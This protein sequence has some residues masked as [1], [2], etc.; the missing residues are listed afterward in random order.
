MR[1]FGILS[2]VMF[3]ATVAS[4]GQSLPAAPAGPTDE[5]IVHQRVGTSLDSAELAYFGLFQGQSPRVDSARFGPITGGY[6]VEPFAQ[7]HSQKIVF[8]PAAQN[9]FLRFIAWYERLALNP[10]SNLNL[11]LLRPLGVQEPLIR[12]ER[13]GRFAEVTLPGGTYFGELLFVSNKAIALY[14]VDLGYEASLVETSVKIFPVADVT[15]LKVY[16]RSFATITGLATGAAVGVAMTVQGYSPF[17][18]KNESAQYAANLLVFPALGAG[19]GF[20]IDKAYGIGFSYDMKNP[21]RAKKGL[22]RA[23]KKVM[24]PRELP[25]EL[26]R[27]LASVR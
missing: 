17:D 9:E 4:Y 20:L 5:Q 21:D 10:P 25:P 12:H 22:A 3:L 27:R 11:N 2:I 19:I 6:Y 8:T 1:K 26:R 23:R 24:F 18:I 13:N 15:R 14:D 16:T 7:G